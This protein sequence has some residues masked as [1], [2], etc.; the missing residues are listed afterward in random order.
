[1]GKLGEAVVEVRAD[2]RQLNA[3]L[4]GAEAHAQAFVGRTNGILKAVGVG[5]LAG[6]GAAGG[7][8]LYDATR[9]AID[10]GE[11]A[12]KVE[13]I[14]GGAAGKI[15]AFA[16]DM[17]RRFGLV[18]RE[19][20]DGAS[21]LGTLGLAAGMTKNQAAD[22]G[23]V[24]AKLGA[25]FS[26]LMNMPFDQVLEKLRSGLAGESEPLR[27]LGIFLT[28]DAVKAEALRLKL[29]G[30][31][32]SLSEGA[33][34]AARASLIKN[35]PA[36]KL[37]DGDLERTA[38]SAANQLRKL[39]GDFENF[40]TEFGKNLIGPLTEGLALARELGVVLDKGLG[41]NGKQLGESAQ[42]W[43]A[44]VRLAAKNNV[45]NDQGGGKSLLQ[46]ANE[47]AGNKTLGENGVGFGMD[48]AEKAEFE[49]N[50][51][52][53]KAKTA[54]WRQEQ[55]AKTL[56]AQR[57]NPTPRGRRNLEAARAEQFRNEG[58]A[59]NRHRAGAD[60]RTGLVQAGQALASAA[61]SALHG[62]AGLVG[63][64]KA[65]QLG[66]RAALGQAAGLGLLPA[67]VAKLLAGAA[68]AVNATA[69]EVAK[70]KRDLGG[71]GVLHGADA[72]HDVAQQMAL[73]DDTA[74]QQLEA[75]KETAGKVGESLEVLKE[76][77]RK[78]LGA[79]RA[80]VQ[81]RS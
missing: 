40:K 44:G 4:A 16:D 72:F 55:A 14:F 27:G 21:A 25:D 39:K 68:G 64:S 42:A 71:G 18:K 81:G 62:G 56:A 57:A 67:P 75:A 73:Q 54:V 74:K 63:G 47:Q 13:V 2:V 33:K 22:L 6:V 9:S 19:T 28:E 29:T 8:F 30:V 48:A 59:W 43:V 79:A 7:K 52:A 41:G 46:Q 49:A 10:F 3:G 17:A 51:K 37:A 1:M 35:A 61:I 23:V 77:A 15:N 12:S 58:E 26:S 60:A 76:I 24:M 50:L 34:I 32:G 80:V 31:N 11:T 53:A 78:G 20:L 5:T 36:A 69:T 66:G 70:P 45:F 65:E 38:G